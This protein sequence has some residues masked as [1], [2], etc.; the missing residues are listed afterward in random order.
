M[1]RQ[2]AC[3]WRL[4][5]S[6]E[7]PG[8]GCALRQYGDLGIP[9]LGLMG[10]ALRSRWAWLWRVS[11]DK[12]WQGLSVPCS[13]NHSQ[14]KPGLE[15]ITRW[16]IGW[17]PLK[18]FSPRIKLPYSETHKYFTAF[19]SLASNISPNDEDV[20]S[21]DITMTTLCIN[22]SK[23]HMFYIRFTCYIFE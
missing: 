14:C 15:R 19:H 3:S 21:S 7:S 12:S 11:S 10:I 4:L 8:L 13:L 1:G 23:A 16:H 17:S 9:N 22:K 5:L 2:G 6:A 20:T 18:T